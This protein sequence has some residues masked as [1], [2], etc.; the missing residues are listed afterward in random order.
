MMNEQL[1]RAEILKQV[2]SGRLRAGDAVRLLKRAG[3]AGAV[4]EPAQRAA[5]V[6]YFQTEWARSAPARGDGRLPPGD[7]LLFDAGDGI[8]ERLR[9]RW[10]GGGRV[11]LVKPGDG[12]REIA[13]DI[14][15]I[16]PARPEDHARLLE[17]LARRG[18]APRIVL[19]VAP[20]GALAPSEAVADVHLE[21]GVL[22]LF[23]S[24]RS[25][26]ERRERGALHVLHVSAVE[27]GEPQPQHAGVAGFARSLR[28][29]DPRV[30]CRAVAL[31]GAPDP[32]AYVDAMLLELSTDDGAAEV[33]HAGGE[34]F[35][36][37]VAPLDPAGALPDR[38]R[39]RE[40][41][42]Y[43]ITGGAGGLGA[44]L[45]AALA[46]ASRVRLVL[47]GRSGMDARKQE[48]VRSLS[49]G[50][51]DVHYASADLSRR[52]DVE[53]LVREARRRCGA[54]H[55][56]VHAAGV[57]ADALLVNKTPEAVRSVLL[58]KVRGSVWLDE[59]TKGDELDFFVLFSSI[60]AVVGSAGQCDY[61][62]A[63]AFLD[64]LA[65]WREG[66]R[67]L[68]RRS[69]RTVS[70]DWP[71]WREGGMTV[72]AAHRASLE[73]AGLALLDTG[74]GIEAF[75]AALRLPSP[76]VVVLYGDP[77]RAAAL[78]TAGGGAPAESPSSP[79]E[80]GADLRE[81]AEAYLR[82]LLSSHAKVP[83]ARLRPSE[84][85][86]SFGIDSLMSMTLVRA[87]EKTFGEL[88]KTL[89]FECRT[90]SELA[91]Y[92][93]DNHGEALRA[94]LGAAA[95]ARPAASARPALP[96]EPRIAP[97]ERPREQGARAGAAPG[98]A[99]IEDIAIV[100]LAGRYP[101]ADDLEAFWENI[102]AGK[103]CIVEVP[104]DR[105][106][107]DRFYAPDRSSPGKSYSKW[108][109]F[110]SDVDRFDPLFFNISP[111]EAELI[112]PQERLFLEVAWHAVEDAAYTRERLSGRKVGVYVGVMYGQYQLY[113]TESASA[114]VYGSSYASIANRV[115]YFFNF[116]GPSIAL[117]TMCSSSLTAIHLA[118]QSIFLGECELAIA[119]GV[120]VTI[121][122]YKYQMLSQGRF[123]AT[124]GRCRSFGEGGDGY[125][126]GEGVG[127][128]LL[129]PLRL[130][131]RDRD[132]IH[133]VIK[134]SAVN[135]GGK[136]N[137]F[138]VPSP[139]AQAELVADALGK[140]GLDARRVSYI[141]AH[142]TGT[143]L[144]DPIEIAGLVK[145]F[146]EASGREA[147][148]ERGVCPIGSVKSNI[149][150]LEAAAGIAAVTKVLLQLKHRQI[151]PSIH[152]SRLNPN[153]RF[154]ETPFYVPQELAPW[155]PPPA[156]E[157]GAARP[158]KRQAGVSGFGAGG[159][160]AHLILEEHLD[161]RAAPA[162]P[163]EGPYLF[164]LS[165]R[166]EDRLKAYAQRLLRFL[167]GDAAQAWPA[168]PPPGARPLEGVRRELL[169][170]VASAIDVP[171]SE[172]SADEDLSACAL[173]RLAAIDLSRRAARHFGL[174]L[175]PSL[176]VDSPTLA[177]LAEG[178]SE[179]LARQAPR[180]EPQGADSDLADLAYT[181]QVGR[182]PM[183]E[184]LAIVASTRDEL[185][186]KLGQHLEGDDAVEGL[187]RGAFKPGQASPERLV[188]GKVGREFVQ[189]LLRE[190]EL[191]K[192]AQLWAWGADIDWEQLHGG[193]G[194][195]RRLR[196]VAAP[197]Y[198][199]ARER[200]WVREAASAEPPRAGQAP[201]IDRDTPAL[202]EGRLVA[203]RGG[204]EPA[205]ELA[206]PAPA[207]VPRAA[208]DRAARPLA[209]RLADD[210]R[211]MA[212]AIV[213]LDPDRLDLDD[214]FADVGFDSTSFVSLAERLGRTYGFEVSPAIFFDRA[215]ARALSEHLF[216]E[217]EGSLR[218]HYA[219]P[220]S[221]PPPGPP[222][223]DPARRGGAPPSLAPRSAGQRGAPRPQASP[224]ASRGGQRIAIIGMSGRFPGSRDLD[225]FWENLRDERDLITE[226][227]PDRWR[228]QDHEAKGTD[229]VVRARA[230]WGGF[231][232]DVDKFDAAFFNISA[233]EAEMMD[234]Q[235]RLL[236]ETVWKT[237]EDSGYRPS[238][239]SGR[240]VGLFVGAQFS[241]YR[242]LLAGQGELNAQMGLGNEHSILVNRISYLLNLR[243]PSEPY[244]TACSSALVALHRA[245]SSLRSG[246]SELAIAG[247]VTLMLS[248]YTTLGGDALGIL[249][250]DGRCKT[251]DA[252]ADGY[253]RGEGVGTVL[254]KPLE[255]AIEDSDHIYAVI[256]GTALNHGGRAS[257][258]TAPSSE[259]QA[260]L[261]VD[262][263]EA[264][265][266]DPETLSYL[267]LH[268]TGTKLGD[269]IEIEGIKM[270]FKELA[271]RRGKPVLREGYC[272][273]G[274]VKTNIG[275]L[276]PAAGIAGLMKVVLSMVH[277]TLPGMLHL[278]ELNPYVELAR[279]P[280]RVVDRT[281]PWPALE[282]DLGR[283]VPRRAGVSS[284]G[285]GGVNAHVVLEEPPASPA[286]EPQDGAP[287]L[288]VL[289][290]KTRDRLRASAAELAAFLDRAL[291]SGRAPALGDVAFT[292][293]V[294]REEM[295]ERLA[296]M[297]GTLK[298]ARDA[299]SAFVEDRPARAELH[300]GS[301]RV[302]RSAPAAAG[303][304]DGAA[305]AGGDL[306]E[307]ARRWAAGESV[308]WTELHRGRRRRLSLPTYPLERKRH[309]AV[310]GVAPLTRTGAG[311]PASATAGEPPRAPAAPV[312]GG[313]GEDDAM[314]AELRGIIAGELKADPE[315]LDLDT[316]F[317]EYG[318]DSI[319]ASVIIQRLQER[320]GE[321][322]P[323]MAM[324][325][326][327]TLRRLAA[328]VRGAGGRV[329][330]APVARAPQR[331]Q[332]KLPPEIIPLNN[333][334]SRRPSFWV[335]GGPGYAAIYNN[336]TRALGP[337][338]PFYAFQ[339]RGVDNRQIPQDFEEM[340][341]HYIGCM[342]MVQPEGPYAIGG[343]SYGGLVAYEMAQRLHREGA[344]VSHLVI[345]DT[346]PA[347]QEAN[348]IFFS[349][350]GGDDDFLTIMMANEFAG[351][352]RLGKAV[353]TKKDLE[354]VPVK[355]QVAHAAKLAKERGKNAMSADEIYNYIRGCIKLGDY[356]EVVYLRHKQEPYD[357]SDV[358]YLKAREFL[359]D[360]TWTGVPAYDIFRD[361]DYPGAWKRLV[362]RRC[363]VV[364]IPSDHFNLLEEPALSISAS[365]VRAYLDS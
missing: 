29:E 345:F 251:L 157:P 315:S 323:M 313:G 293:Q 1:T 178:I 289:S 203:G 161:E 85:F 262:A 53:R 68:G 70:I 241:D 43:L 74:A 193:Q 248:P 18:A 347:T 119:G 128:V 51:S 98:G 95:P 132:R 242:Q 301:I 296:F 303:A 220:A 198:P 13:P 257:S 240:R 162:A 154:E 102:K 343:Y 11:A 359:A 324:S 238:E 151:A 107:H 21:R 247:G 300:V 221:A 299:L 19:H 218:A 75:H 319:L 56:V 3:A 308:P 14:H 148:G 34:R 244:N 16:H 330:P 363:D 87:L 249:S 333:R 275:H 269:P 204:G 346:M 126:P 81:A 266:V 30:R 231:I 187:F 202:E 213:R 176:F 181:L 351:A 47:A 45:A 305:R 134:S 332:P 197:T 365:S 217:H 357:G 46:S 97:A 328:F 270:A 252:S 350:F 153:I 39:V 147:R 326:Q 364:T 58:P 228:W 199:F 188:E 105:W 223:E 155:A 172:V 49:A 339:A 314:L 322:I 298:E 71:L 27:G 210:V 44:R 96:D 256:Q 28:K 139:R 94:Q 190:R 215:S 54:I 40:G 116:T 72:D 267:E 120:N 281:A 200:Y 318:I 20:R 158:G 263:F 32:A 9:A 216:A 38:A 140:V 212:A 106:D 164:V 6:S 37:R 36:R 112:D 73:E 5:A 356:T 233:R 277:R 287:H 42:G 110:L 169:E 196:R 149:G 183:R 65:R 224:E 124:D 163:P 82:S 209:A 165:A 12:Y 52:E 192:L 349:S 31:D 167:G 341:Q 225:H 307:L 309:W 297:A 146:Q 182:E 48:L 288:V 237:I 117:D 316:E 84:P 88:P 302:R 205:G 185:A 93:I 131:V 325:E 291:S 156:G 191:D 100:G 250:P 195:G 334:G 121:H 50:G 258:L 306:A 17:E 214:R 304:P 336:L 67:A 114:V 61:G 184:R 253:V 278:K 138:T 170:L 234:P 268:G 280:F 90:L 208:V 141:E 311:E 8:F 83:P 175:E 361:Y 152:S 60:A 229:G 227:P 337:D 312:D 344:G 230:R 144:G 284:F 261:L 143:A 290:A 352:R 77:A 355:L 222:R 92:F 136:T 177:A 294:G 166:T 239:L 255:R 80:G 235:Q 260:A 194:G 109:G 62:Y 353:V 130:A 15:A 115:S 59:L 232:D 122:P 104:K 99:L 272:G 331:S 342:R 118:C 171:V 86:E 285:F 321:L 273:L 179:R 63:N 89:F 4:P 189:M 41:G 180:A 129:K 274:S 142:G 243:G 33:R 245:V 108:G 125:V 159:A 35:T 292:L 150:H 160:N 113:S 354:G 226:V 295:N 133:G 78:L 26:L 310:S 135:H 358:L 91:V 282:D 127:A 145:A 335:H 64:E 362:Q 201:R 101:M 286:G 329:E 123:A 2:E 254:L 57:L 271:G 327:P 320:F 348:D 55:G 173:D 338:Y 265:D 259:A 25:L 79:L 279:T 10:T 219:E 103:D 340:I 24:V 206:P 207:D 283:P 137:G 211:R 276:E 186:R 174:P 66:Q 22:A 246:E 168:V 7:V 360:S 236:L 23:L 317:V 69:G 111:A 76:Q 264:A